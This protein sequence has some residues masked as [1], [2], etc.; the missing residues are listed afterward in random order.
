MKRKTEVTLIKEILGLKATNSAFLDAA[1]AQHS[2]DRYICQKQFQRERRSIFLNL[3][4]SVAHINELPSSGDFLVRD[5]A[6]RSVLITRDKSNKVNAFLNVCRHRGTRLVDD[7]NGCKRR[8]SCPYH[9]WTYANTGELIAAPHFEQGFPNHRKSDLGL[10]RLNCAEKYGFIWV[11]ADPEATLNFDEYFGELSEEF[12]ELAISEM[13]VAAQDMQ[14]RPINWKTIIEGG[15]ES[16]HFK[17]AHKKTIGPY[18]EDNLSTYKAYGPHMRSVLPRSTIGQL[19]QKS[20]DTWRLR[21]HANILYTLFP[22]CQLLLQQD[23]V[24]W[25][26]IDPLSEGQ[27]RLRLITL[28]P[29]DTNKTDDYWQKNHAITITTLNEDFDIGES[30]QANA[31]NGTIETLLF[32]RFEGALQTFNQSVDSFT[33]G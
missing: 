32:G 9:A 14:L 31:E 12:E 27:T 26:S 10:T 15:I 20:E 16:Y 33:K 1:P 8:F 17:V 2:I 13:K 22:T 3:P 6:G 24:I 5:V 7:T 21:D 30:I 25:I 18:F 23:H 11:I 29:N 4:R 28:V 19:A